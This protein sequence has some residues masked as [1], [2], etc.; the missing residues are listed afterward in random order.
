MKRWGWIGVVGLAL[1]GSVGGFDSVA[2]GAPRPGGQF[3]DTTHGIHVFNDQIDLYG[4]SPELIQFVATHYDGTQKI[5]VDQ[6]RAVRAVNPDFVVLHYRLGFGL[7]YRTVEGDCQPTGEYL[8]IMDGIDWVQEWPATEPP[9]EFFYHFNGERLYM[10]DWGWYVMDTDNAAY[11]EWWLTQIQTQLANGEYDGLFADSVSVPNSLGAESFRPILPDL[12]E[13][14]EAD[15]TRRLQ[16]WM[17]WLRDALGDD[18]VLIPN[19]GAWITT[20]D[21]TDYSLADGI[22]IESFVGW[23]WE[24]RFAFEDWELQLNRALSLI[25]Q[26]TIVI[27]QSYVED[28]PDQV[29]VLANYLLIKGAHTYVNID[30][31]LEAEWFPLYALPVDQPID[32]VPD[33]IADLLDSSGLYVRRYTHALI[34]VN[35]DPTGSEKTLTL[36]QTMTLVTGQTDGGIVPE[37]GNVSGWTWTGTPVQSVTVAPGQAAILIIE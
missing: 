31:G 14:F 8:M 13:A 23:G 10:C 20:R 30:T 28:F 35:P 32:E 33:Q 27:A 24:D 18:Y 6:T 4:A 11:R 7:G 1:I 3:P 2:G 29:W 34:L 16:E 37:D 17:I 5:P 36:D 15:W 12:D 21:Q 22:M 25:T 9:E 26:D 19:A